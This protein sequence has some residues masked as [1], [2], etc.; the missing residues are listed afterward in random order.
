MARL[1]ESQ[2]RRMRDEIARRRRLRMEPLTDQQM[3]AFL[4]VTYT[5]TWTSDSGGYDSSTG[6]C[7]SSYDS[8]SSSSSCS[9]SGSSSCGGGGGC[10]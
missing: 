9:D 1:T 4:N 6:S 10:D 3:A 2:R 7:G 8:G 5:S